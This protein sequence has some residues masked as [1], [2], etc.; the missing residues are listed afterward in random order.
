MN[1]PKKEII[2]EWGKVLFVEMTSEEYEEILEAYKKEIFFF[3]NS[4]YRKDKEYGQYL[5]RWF[6]EKEC[7]GAPFSLKYKWRRLLMNYFQYIFG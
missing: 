5:E 7:D 6:S 1:Y 2:S 3:L 4:K